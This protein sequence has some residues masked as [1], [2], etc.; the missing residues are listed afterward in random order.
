MKIEIKGETSRGFE[1]V[2]LA[3]ENLW[4]GIEVGSS[5]CIFHKGEKVVDLWGGYQDRDM[6]REWMADT[7]VNVYSTSKGIAALAIAVLHDEGKIDYQ[8]KVVT[9]WP[10]FG[11]E[12]K[13]GITVAELLSHQ[14]G[15]CGVN[16]RLQVSDLYD[17]QKMV[18]LLAAQKPLW[19]PGKAA[20]YHAV[21]WGFLAGELVRRI[22]GTR[23]TEYLQEKIAKPLEADFYL[24]LQAG[25][26]ERCAPLIGPNHARKSEIA[27]PQKRTSGQTSPQQHFAIAL[28]NPA[29]SPF[30]DACS[31]AWREAEIAASNGHASARG[32]ATIYAALSM[33]GT[34]NGTKII[35]TGALDEALQ[36]EVDGPV[37]QVLGG[38]I[39]R[40]RGFM[41]NTDEAYGPNPDAFGH[42]G[43]GGSLGFADRQAG[44]GFGYVM[45]QM[46]N[47]NISIPRSEQLV[48]SLYTC[49]EAR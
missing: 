17:W 41:L 20:G 18:N 26:F 6:T 1:P 37:D 16:T 40:A 7:L 24:G 19:Q 44:V 47:D 3:Y 45:N 33:D 11:A 31:N 12:N 25:D 39:R 48:E 38:K 13:T 4:Q 21:T 30:K 9:Y 14:A 27:P 34:L 36:V 15:L 43:A 46:Q 2:R 42:A 32:I 23:L 49:L 22:T 5:L 10:E 35:S 29:I 28:M 8:E